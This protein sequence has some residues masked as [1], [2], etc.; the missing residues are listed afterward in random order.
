MLLLNDSRNDARTYS[1]STLT[2]RETSSFFDSDSRDKFNFHLS[3][4]ARHYHFS[5][6]WKMYDTSYVS[7]T[8]V[9]LRTVVSE[10]W[11]MTSTLFFRKYINFSFETAMWSD[12]TWFSKYL[13]TLDIFT[14]YTTK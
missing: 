6:F 2:D 3:V 1:T 14:R 13:T 4:I 5:T 10:E 11:S 8:E 12:C 7:C 9:E